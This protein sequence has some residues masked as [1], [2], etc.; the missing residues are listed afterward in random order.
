[1]T[2]KKDVCHKC[3][4]AGEKLFLKG[5]R[6]FSAKCSFTRRSYPPGFHG[7]AR[8]Q[9]LSEFK[10]QLLE[11]QKLRNLYNL[12]D[13][14]FKNN[15]VKA[16]R[17]DLPTQQALIQRLERRLD[18][19]VYR[20]GFGISRSN[21]RQMV[22]HGHILV[23]GKKID[24]PSYLVKAEEKISLKDKKIELTKTEIPSWLE[25]D[26]NKVGKVVYLPKEED[27]SSNIDLD[28][29]IEYYSR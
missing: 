2:V 4:R 28:Q 3:R 10:K 5:S 16:E 25:L 19:V 9:K 1:M 12:R 27:L 29:I 18:N 24:L 21:A 7:Q 15:F 22:N 20:L 26:K 13:R 6:C 11:K 8:V 14:Q 23:D 17:S